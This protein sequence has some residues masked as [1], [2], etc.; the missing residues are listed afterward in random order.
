MRAAHSHM[1]ASGLLYA[2]EANA[3]AVAFVIADGPAVIN[4]LVTGASAVF[5]QGAWV[6]PEPRVQPSSPSPLPTIEYCS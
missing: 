4:T 1:T 3:L 6:G 5:P 2:I